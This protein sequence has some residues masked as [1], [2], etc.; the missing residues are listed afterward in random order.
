[1]LERLF[2]L[3]LKQYFGEFI[4]GI[5]SVELAL[6]TGKIHFQ[7]ASLKHEKLNELFK[8]KNIPLSLKYSSIGSL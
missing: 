6:W 7:N 3:L 4:T 8:E 5:D 1:M 2:Q